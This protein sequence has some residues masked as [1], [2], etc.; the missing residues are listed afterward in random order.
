MRLTRAG[1]V[2]GGVLLA[3]AVTLGGAALPVGASTRHPKGPSP[4][5]KY[6]AAAA[7]ANSAL[8]KFDSDVGGSPSVTTVAAA[9]PALAAA[10]T[11]FAYTL[12]HIRWTTAKSKKDA[13]SLETYARTVA[14]FL[15]TANV[16]T[17]STLASWNTQLGVIASTGT[18]AISTLRRDLGIG[19]P[20]TLGTTTTTPQT[21]NVGQSQGFQ[22]INGASGSVTLD[23]VVDPA[24]NT[25]GQTATSDG[26]RFVALEFTVK[27]LDTSAI[28]DA[29][30]NDVKA[31]TSA[32][33]GFEADPGEATTE[34]PTFPSGRIDVAPNGTA[35]GWILIDVPVTDDLA[36]VVFSVPFGNNSVTWNV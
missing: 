2:F 22:F 26:G 32:G 20:A 3:L 29:I 35:T 8:A 17:A 16:Q 30:D 1:N 27:D 11:T 15:A 5:T 9:A 6:L 7:K 18:T 28:S 23:Q 25:E 4:A 34:G 21:Y 19:A 36:T 10:N 33:E 13:R 31:Y 14:Q 12:T 24:A